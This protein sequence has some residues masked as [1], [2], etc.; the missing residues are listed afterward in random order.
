MIAPLVFLA[1]LG[2]CYWWM[3]R[4][5]PTPQ[6]TASRA[7]PTRPT[8]R[9]ASALGLEDDPNR[10]HV[11]PRDWTALD[12]LQLLRLLTD[13]IPINPPSTTTSID[14]AIPQ[15]TQKDTT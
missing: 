7:A 10:W 9:T 13:S 1:L 8:A 3:L 5:M 15:C 6:A 11:T 2:C 4:D 12:E 14:D